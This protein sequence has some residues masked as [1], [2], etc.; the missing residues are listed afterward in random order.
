MFRSLLGV[1]LSFAWFI[2]IVAFVTNGWLP[3][4]IGISMIPAILMYVLYIK[5]RREYLA[6]TR[7]AITPERVIVRTRR[8]GHETVKEFV[9]KPPSR[10]WQWYLRHTPRHSSQSPPQGIV[11]APQGYD[12]EAGDDPNDLS[13]PRFGG[14]LTRGEMDWVEWR[15]NLFLD[16][17]GHRAEPESSESA[18]PPARKNQLVRIDQ[19]QHETLIT[20]PTT[21]ATGSFTGIGSLFFGLILLTVSC[22]PFIVIW[23]GAGQMSAGQLSMQLAYVAVFGILGLAGTLN[24]LAQLFGERRLTISPQWV[25]YR[26]SVFGIGVWWTLPTADILSVWNPSKRVAGRLPNRHIAGAAGAVIRTARREIPLNA[27]R[28]AVRSGVDPRWL[29]DEISRHIIA[30]RAH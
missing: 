5:M 20:F 26:A 13:K 23:N 1:A 2:A 9:L 10:A 21:V 29:A 25:R 15:V 12:I 6:D 27:A 22:A 30:A 3:A 18:K 24:G 19:D 11:I 14:N 7:V 28:E 8:R 16:R 17:H 4:V